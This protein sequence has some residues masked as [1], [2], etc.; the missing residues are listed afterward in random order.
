MQ[1]VRQP[2]IVVVGA[3]AAGLGAAAKLNQLGFTDVTLLEASQQ[4]GGRIAKA[5]LG[6]CFILY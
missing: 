4:V 3:G 2:R 5:Q 6:A 1:E